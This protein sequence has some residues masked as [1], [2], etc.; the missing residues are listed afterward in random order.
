M[1]GEG[2]AAAEQR[3]PRDSVRHVNHCTMED[4]AGGSFGGGGQGAG[5]A[6]ASVFSALG[7]G[8]VLPVQ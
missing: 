4:E 3:R 6:S 1:K 8:Q 2:A 5:G 7:G